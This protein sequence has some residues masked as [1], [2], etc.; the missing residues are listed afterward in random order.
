MRSHRILPSLVLP[1]LLAI[2]ARPARA[3]WHVDGGP[4][5][6]ALNTQA[7]QAIIPDGSGGVIIVWEDQRGGA[8][9][10]IYAQHVLASGAV[11]PS[12]PANGQVLCSALNNQIQP[13]IASD[14]AGGAIVTW[15]DLRPGSNS[16]IYA[17]HV[18]ASGAVD[19]A[20]PVNGRALC[21]AADD[22]FFQQVVADG[23]G[24]AIV[25]WQDLRAGFPN[26]DIYA[27]HV[28]A[29]GALDA[30]WPANGRALCAA[31][32]DQNVP[33]ITSDGAGGAIVAW[34]DYRSGASYHIYAQRV[35]ASGAV[36]PGWPVDGRAVCTAASS[37]Y[38]P[39]IISDGAGG[40]ILTWY[41]Y[42]VAD[43]DI[44][45][46]HVLA[47]GAN[48]P[49]WPVD[50]RAICT[51]TNHQREPHLVPDGAGGAI[52]SWQDS[53]GVG[54]DIY[55]QHIKSTGA[56][57]PVW[58]A[59]GRALCSATNNQILPQIIGDGVGGAIVTWEDLR[60]GSDY[61]I[62]AQH[63]LSSGAV[64]PA[65]T[66]DGNALCKAANDQDSPMIARDGSGGA[67]VAWYDFRG[68]D[69]DI[70][71]SRVYASGGLADVPRSA[72]RAGLELDS[73]YPN[74][75]RR[76][77]ITI[78]FDLPASARASIDV[79]DPSGRRVRVVALDRDV[80]AGHQAIEWDGRDDRGARVP[81]GLYFVRLRSAGRSVARPLVVVD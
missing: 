18:L 77:P 22:Q 38:S 7:N 2:F 55:T 27:Q 36:D 58:P 53:R 67:I 19:P 51:A 30:A 43:F 26:Y 68:A 64:D 33:R 56:V 17:Q 59:D 49:A 45:A 48:D 32:N 8:V 37:Q 73:P 66:A 71:A 78:S 11:D 72:A 31:A 76:S 23:A 1:M 16:D 62:F 52:I 39:E 54:W 57:D 3:Q 14:G 61:D 6:T 24:G 21:T 81:V 25:T 34:Y 4:V 70:Y 13:A 29:T 15:Q 9:S 35:L 28:L 20:W 75:S 40:A 69:S 42:R 47:S 63:V 65:W 12:W 60:S 41:D 80:P 50:G 5:C 79:L 10:D 46:Q 44:Y 74:P